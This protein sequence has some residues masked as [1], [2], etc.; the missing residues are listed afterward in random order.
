MATVT[1]LAGRVT[2]A[3]V[4]TSV[5]VGRPVVAALPETVE[6]I[7]PSLVAVGTLNK[8]RSPAY[9]AFGT[10]FVV[11]DGTM[12]AT[13]AHVAAIMNRLDEHEA[14]TVLVRSESGDA[15]A[16]PAREL[17]S[18]PE[19]D[20]VLLKIEGRP[21]P[22]LRL[23]VTDG[24]DVREGQSVAFSG[25]PLVGVLGFFPA[26]NRSIISAIAP[27]AIPGAAASQLTEKQIKR[28]ASGSFEI[29]QL[30]ASA[31]PG[32]SGSPLY[33]VDSGEVIGIIN[34][35]LVKGTKES[36][37][38]HPSGITYAIPVRYLEALLKAVD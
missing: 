17:A 33:D 19:H 24:A 29:Y 10:G 4:L 2:L 1:R 5:I 3:M 25:F 35:V 38:S 11:G 36:A 20:L 22:A 8:F 12:V 7:R 16:R 34:M 30:D 21:L 23:A 18:D 31:Y 28:L 15:Q 26:T 6:L 9:Q 37:L 13:N 32:S 14:L 27:V